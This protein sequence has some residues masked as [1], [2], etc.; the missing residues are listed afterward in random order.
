MPVSFAEEIEIQGE[1]VRS[2]APFVT[3]AAPR[4]EDGGAVNWALAAF[5]DDSSGFC[6]RKK[7]VFFLKKPIPLTPKKPNQTQT[8]QPSAGD[9]E[10]FM[11]TSARVDV[12]KSTITALLRLA[13]QKLG[14]RARPKAITVVSRKLRGCFFF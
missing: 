9:A 3:I 13:R 10:C 2:P 5:V 14:L 7:H 4:I 11:S 6:S 1:T 12:E 8:K